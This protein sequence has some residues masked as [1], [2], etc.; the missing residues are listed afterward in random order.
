VRGTPDLASISNIVDVSGGREH[1]IALTDSGT[2]YTWGSDAYG[3]LGDGLPLANKSSPVQVT[4]LTGVK[5]VD[6][7]HYHSLALK[8]DGT[9]WGWGQNSL[10][11]LAQGNELTR[12]P[13]P[14]QWGTISDAVGIYGGRDMTYVLSSNGT[15]WCSG[16]QGLEC[17]RANQTAKITKPVAINGLPDIAEIAGGRNHAVA[18]AANGTVWTWGVNDYGQL[19]DGTKTDRPTPQQVAGLSNIVDV[20]AGAEH[21]LAVDAD[22]QVY[23]W[24]RNYRG[25]LGIGNTTDKLQPTAVPGLSGI[26][27]VDA[28]RSHS[29]AIGGNGRLWVWGWNETHQ[30]NGSASAAVVNPYEVPGLTDVVAAGGG[31]A[32]SV[33]LTHPV[34]ALLSDGFDNGLTNWTVTGRLRVDT[35]RSSPAGDAPSVRASVTNR[36]AGAVRPLPQSSDGVCARVWVRPGSASKTT[37]LLALRESSGTGIAQ[38]QVTPNGS[39]MVRDDIDN[40][41]ADTGTTLAFQQWRQIE[42]CTSHLQGGSDQVRVL[43]GGSE[44][45][46]WQWTTATV[47]QVQIGSLTKTSAAFNLDDVA[48]F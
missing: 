8:T 26:V 32:Y 39:L 33:A 36:K 3:Q 48:V 47:G 18:L 38:L 6:D 42:L 31:Q 11:Q 15:V 44:V 9:V 20:G 12:V 28:G 40:V 35:T 5:D 22:G 46:T 29:F 4:G 17:G 37:T 45:G 1:V 13:A 21:S 30:V 14:S 10:G 2:V 25:E 19:G 34:T 7:G 27:E 43:V 24:G 16:G 41:S 23:A